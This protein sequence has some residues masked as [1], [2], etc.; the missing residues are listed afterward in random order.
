MRFA[1]PLPSSIAFF[2]HLLFSSIFFPSLFS[3]SFSPFLL[4]I[5][6]RKSHDRIPEKNSQAVVDVND[7]SYPKSY[8]SLRVGSS[9]P[10]S[11]PCPLISTNTTS[12]NCHQRRNGK[13]R[14]SNSGNNKANHNRNG[15]QRSESMINFSKRL[16]ILTG[17]EV[18]FPASEDHEEV[19][20]VSGGREEG[21]EQEERNSGSE[22]RGILSNH[23]DHSSIS[24]RDVI[25]IRDRLPTPPVRDQSTDA[26]VQYRRSSISTSTHHQQDFA[27]QGT[28]TS[29]SSSSSSCTSSV[30]GKGSSSINR[31][32][33]R[34]VPPLRQSS[35]V[36]LD[37][38][39]ITR[40]GGQHNQQQQQQ[41][42]LHHHLHHHPL[43]PLPAPNHDSVRRSALLRSASG[44]AAGASF[45]TLGSGPHQ[46][47]GSATMMPGGSLVSQPVPRSL[48]V[49]PA[50]TQRSLY[51]QHIFSQPEV[52]VPVFCTTSRVPPVSKE[53]SSVTPLSWM[54]D[55]ILRHS[56]GSRQE[57]YN[58]GN[59]KTATSEFSFCRPD[60]P[61]TLPYNKSRSFYGRPVSTTGI[62]SSNPSIH[63]TC[64]GVAIPASGVASSTGSTVLLPPPRPPL[65]KQASLEESS[66][67]FRCSAAATQAQ[68]QQRLQAAAAA[69]AAASSSSTASNCIS[70]GSTGSTSFSTSIDSSTSGG[71][72]STTSSSARS[73]SLVPESAADFISRPSSCHYEDSHNFGE[74]QTLQD[75]T[76]GI[77]L[78]DNNTKSVRKN[79]MNRI[80]E[81]ST[82]QYS[83]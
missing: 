24:S 18:L 27:P 42:H 78:N 48:Q 22:G 5:P 14:N 36:S 46:Y 11:S 4:P 49:S 29:I 75:L 7:T 57:N 3:L 55:E 25:R 40:S 71:S 16:S 1:R 41:H 67:L 8:S 73:S 47:I 52:P 30:P 9:R 20:S 15:N 6:C 64:D 2:A 69:A 26:S 44:I 54:K 37:R 35:L 51:A 10:T 19:N 23:P 50:L 63:T 83:Q 39:L 13:N 80:L 79:R 77:Q 17:K 33:A 59:M 12:I 45:S 21:E 66:T 38:R 76:A 28:S 43:P 74:Q 61:L 68:R 65:P 82:V 34:I 81:K 58:N 72:C 31:K 62:L 53:R 32:E 60:S 70:L 56:S